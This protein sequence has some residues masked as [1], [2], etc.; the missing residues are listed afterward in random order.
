MNME[1]QSLAIDGVEFSS[2]KSPKRQLT[3]L[4]V[5]FISLVESAANGRTFLAK[6]AEHTD[7]EVIEKQ[8]PIVK[9][10]KIKKNGLRYRICAG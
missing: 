3:D 8:I 9:T 4:Q 2:G 5:H 7:P 10:D 1:E 6:Q